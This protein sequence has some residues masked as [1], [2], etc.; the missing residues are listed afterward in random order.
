MAILG[1]LFKIAYE[2]PG[3][4][5]YGIFTNASG[6]RNDNYYRGNAVLSKPGTKKRKAFDRRFDQIS[7]DSAVPDFALAVGMTVSSAELKRLLEGAVRA[8]DEVEP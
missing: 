8:L 6:L 4:A 2:E 5:F 3:I 1:F 7:L